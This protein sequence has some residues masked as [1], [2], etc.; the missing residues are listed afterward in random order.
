MTKQPSPS[1]AAD[2][3]NDPWKGLNKAKEAVKQGLDKDVVKHKS[4]DNCVKKESAKDETK[5]DKSRIGVKKVNQEYV[6]PSQDIRL[7]DQSIEKFRFIS[8]KVEVLTFFY[9][10][11]IKY[12]S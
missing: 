3:K 4:S 8:E 6:N 1:C 5:P 11:F 9:L 10:S 2:R 12:F 7:R